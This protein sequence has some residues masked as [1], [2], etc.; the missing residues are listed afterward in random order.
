MLQNKDTFLV[1]EIKNFFGKDQK[2][3]RAI[4]RVIESLGFSKSLFFDDKI[5]KKY[6]TENIFAILLLFPFFNQKT[7]ALY[8]NSSLYGLISCRKDLFY[9]FLNDE[10]LDWRKISRN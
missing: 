4:F 7:P 3:I 9:R 10:N 1:S 2:A 8:Q 6:S 5:N